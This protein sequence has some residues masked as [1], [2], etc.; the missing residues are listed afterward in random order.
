MSND[1]GI[2]WELLNIKVPEGVPK[3][4]GFFEI[5][6]TEAS[7][8]VSSRVYAWFLNREQNPVLAPLFCDALL[9]LVQD[10]LGDT[11]AAERL[12]SGRYECQLEVTTSAGNRI[13]ILLD[14]AETQSAIIIENKIHADLTNDLRDYWNHVSYPEAQKLG[15]LLSLY[16][17]EIPEEFKSIFINVTHLEWVEAVE[18]EGV[19]IGMPL[20]TYGMMT[21]FFNAIRNQST[22]KVMS[23]RARF[24]FD[25]PIPVIQAKKCLDEAINHLKSE[26]KE[27]AQRLQ[28]SP[29]FGYLKSDGW[30]YIYKQEHRNDAYYKVIF[31][32]IAYP[33][34]A[35]IRVILEL[36]SNGIKHIALL[37]QALESTPQSKEMI[38]SRQTIG[39]GEAKVVHYRVKEIPWNAD[40]IS[41]L[42]KILVETIQDEFKPMMD[43]I[44]KTLDGL[45]ERE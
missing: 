40:R 28:L 14:D 21:D 43:I 24:F 20:Y 19:P 44:H 3:K 22:G 1:E 41:Q 4:T 45:T 30:C 10:K 39:R 26:L 7:E 37:D 27:V 15:V 38:C 33:K 36:Y 34:S 2:P 16:P 6:G 29:D 11:S 8:L 32:Q 35:P 13:D 25:H 12:L 42:S 17:T 31:D 5:S 18:S 23:D 9:P